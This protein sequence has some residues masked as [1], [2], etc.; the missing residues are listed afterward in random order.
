MR[1]RRARGAGQALV[2]MSLIAPALVILLGGAGQIGA[3]AYGGVTVGTAAREGARIAAEYPNRSLD[4]VSSL[5]RTVYTCGQNPADSETE[6]SVCDAVRSASGLISGSSLTIVI[7]ANHTVSRLPTDIVQAGNAC[8]GGATASGTVSNLPSGTVAILASPSKS[9]SGTVA[10]DS[11]GAYSICLSTPSSSQ[12]TT[13]TATA[14][15]ASG[16]TYNSSVTVTV[17][18]DKSVTPTPANIALPT[19]GSCPTPAATPTPAAA[20]PA[21]STQGPVPTPATTPSCSTVVS[22]S[23]YVSIAVSYGVPIFAPFVNRL[24]ADTPT[25]S[26]RT[27]TATETMQI[28]PCGITQGG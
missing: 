19:S 21:A 28:E 25:G 18:H 16:C 6:G 24:L 10:S 11:T 8:P 7:T 1:R 9:T 27:V 12:Q 15:D 4:F 14:V 17:G 2:E 3:I 20:T 5:G 22:D 23:S 13:I 26:V